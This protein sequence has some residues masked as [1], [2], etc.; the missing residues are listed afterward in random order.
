MSPRSRDVLSSETRERIPPPAFRRGEV[1]VH[2]GEVV[3]ATLVALVL[4]VSVIGALAVFGATR[5][6][7]PTP[8]PSDLSCVGECEGGLTGP[9]QPGT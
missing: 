7:S 9:Q 1:H 3:R 4:T 8:T 2:G 6:P 5:G